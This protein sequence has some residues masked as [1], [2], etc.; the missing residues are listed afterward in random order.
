MACTLMAYRVMAY[1]GTVCTLM[2]YKVMA[3]I[4]YG[5]YSYGLYN[6]GM[7]DAAADDGLGAHTR[8]RQGHR[9]DAGD[10][11]FF[12]GASLIDQSFGADCE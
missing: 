3:Y 11:Y 9:D 1:I 12:H 4:S 6:H 7:L 8:D 10:K 2:A 5:L